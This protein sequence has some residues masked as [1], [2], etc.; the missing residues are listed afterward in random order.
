M[1][2][3]SGPTRKPGVSCHISMAAASGD[4]LDD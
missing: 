1:G 2:Q 4:R 3:A